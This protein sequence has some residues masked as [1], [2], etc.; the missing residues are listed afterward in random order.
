MR[1]FTVYFSLE[2]RQAYTKKSGSKQMKG[3]RRKARFFLTRSVTYYL[4]LLLLLLL[5]PIDN[6]L[7]IRAF[8]FGLHST[9][10]P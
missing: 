4:L 7:A 6:E 5:L 3:K 9:P 1:I 2:G 10:E 8:M